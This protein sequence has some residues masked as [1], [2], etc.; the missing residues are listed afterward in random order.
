MG[1]YYWSKISNCGDLKI[2]DFVHCIN[3]QYISSCL[4]RQ[5]SSGLY[6]NVNIRQIDNGDLDF[7]YFLVDSPELQ[8]IER[9]ACS[10]SRGKRYCF[11]IHNDATRL[12]IVIIDLHGIESF[13]HVNQ[14]VIGIPNILTQADGKVV[15]YV[16]GNDSTLLSITVDPAI[17][18]QI[19]LHRRNG[20]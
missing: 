8:A 6:H 2:E 18:D 17:N 11:G 1:E 19:S 15:C 14:S 5:I 12:L 10:W 13:H 4:L 9:M 16:E 3:E 7:D 20:Q